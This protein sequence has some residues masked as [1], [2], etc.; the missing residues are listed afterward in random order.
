MVT[1]YIILNDTV[2]CRVLTT[3]CKTDQGKR[4][5]PHKSEYTLYRDSG[6][7]ERTNPGTPITRYRHRS[8]V[9]GPTPLTFRDRRLK[10]YLLSFGC[11]KSRALISR[12]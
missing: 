6:R 1:E 12:Y 2:V 5:I 4:P 7:L 3:F 8:L 10:D 9:Q 11:Y